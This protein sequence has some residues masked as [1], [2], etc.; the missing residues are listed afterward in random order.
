MASMPFS[1]RSLGFSVPFGHSPPG[2]T[3]QPDRR[4]QECLL[5]RV[6]GLRIPPA[7]LCGPPRPAIPYRST[8]TRFNCALRTC[9]LEAIL[10]IYLPLG[11]WGTLLLL[12]LV[13]LLLVLL[14]WLLLLLVLLLL[15]LIRL[16]STP[17]PRPG[18]QGLLQPRGQRQIYIYIYIYIT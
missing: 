12:L 9:I 16:L 5:D 10:V 4:A 14:L 8:T 13:L 11:I 6:V 3:L 1:E 7:S 17:P 18:S 2:P 15:S